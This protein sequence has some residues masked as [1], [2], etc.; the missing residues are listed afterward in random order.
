MSNNKRA[1][2]NSLI[3]ALVIAAIA[4]YQGETLLTT[5]L[6][7]IFSGLIFYAALRLSY[8]FSAKLAGNSEKIKSDK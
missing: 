4:V 1:L 6:S 3:L 5:A 7:F 2:R 8:Q